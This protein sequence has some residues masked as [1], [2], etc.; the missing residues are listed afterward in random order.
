M[1]SFKIVF[2][3]AMW[4]GVLVSLLSGYL[5]T[6]NYRVRRRDDPREFWIAWAGSTALAG[7]A[8]YF[9]LQLPS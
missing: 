6:P 9:I 2:M 5:Y 4:L 3:V 1:Q 8:S 7:M